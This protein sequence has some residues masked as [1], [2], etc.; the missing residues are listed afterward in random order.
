MDKT[1]D[2]E[3]VKAE[4]ALEQTVMYPV[5]PEYLHHRDACMKLLWY[6]KITNRGAFKQ[7]FCYI[8]N[9]PTMVKNEKLKNTVDSMMALDVGF[10]HFVE[11]FV[12][13]MHYFLSTTTVSHQS[14]GML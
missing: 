7:V 2:Q 5:T 6:C 8:Y 3:I 4:E 11:V 10:N 13:D 14:T 9:K 1:L 12:K